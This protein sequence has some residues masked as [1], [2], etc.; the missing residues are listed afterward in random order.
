MDSRAIPE[1]EGKWTT[2]QRLMRHN[3]S[4]RRHCALSGPQPT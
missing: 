1:L 2:A 3:N 4:S